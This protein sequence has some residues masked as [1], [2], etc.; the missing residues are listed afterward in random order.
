[1]FVNECEVENVCTRIGKLV[2]YNISDVLGSITFLPSCLSCTGMV[3]N[4]NNDEIIIYALREILLNGC[5]GSQGYFSLLHCFVFRYISQFA[6]M[7]QFKN[8]VKLTYI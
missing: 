3:L 6:E 8:F 4:N 1:M 2:R 7:N 5:K